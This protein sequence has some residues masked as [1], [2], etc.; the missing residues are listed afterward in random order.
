MNNNISYNNEGYELDIWRMISVLWKKKFVIAL[1]CIICAVLVGVGSTFVIKPKYQSDILVYV[2]NGSISFGSISVNAVDLKSARS[3]LDSYL[4]ILQSRTFLTEVIEKADLPYT[5]T[6][7]KNMFTA[8]SVND[9]EFFTV[10]VISDNAVEPRIIADAIGDT[11]PD[12]LMEIMGVNAVTVVDHALSPKKV[13]S[14]GPAAYAL[15]GFLA[16]FVVVGGIYIVLDMM[17]DRI[18]GEEM[19]NGLFNSSIPILAYIPNEESD[20]SHSKYYRTSKYGYRSKYGYSKKYDSD[21]S[22]SENDTRKTVNNE[23]K[24]Q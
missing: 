12:M 22:R 8:S 23:N 1:V 6:Q 9:T 17:D 2:N 24:E 15:L 3:L 4:V 7:L 19:L 5:G 20:G 13:A 21:K 10:T 16:A 11:L 14:L 18:H